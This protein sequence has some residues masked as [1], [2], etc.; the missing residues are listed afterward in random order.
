MG[1]GVHLGGKSLEAVAAGA[2]G[3][4]HGH[5]G[6]ALK[7]EDIEAVLRVDGNAN[8]ARDENIV[9]S[10][11]KR[12][13]ERFDEPAGNAYGIVALT[14]KRQNQGKFVATEPG[15][16]IGVAFSD[17]PSCGDLAE[18]FVARLVTERVVDIFEAV[19][20]DDEEAD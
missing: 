4:I 12:L 10:N 5:V 17:K 14:K 1:L 18:Q 16:R 9:T 19:E 3:A 11:V 15:E 6:V 2:L 20:V 7:R 13:T 8:A